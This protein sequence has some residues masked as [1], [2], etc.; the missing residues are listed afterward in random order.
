L[1]KPL[2]KFLILLHLEEKEDVSSFNAVKIEGYSPKV[3]S[4]HI[5]LL[6]DANFIET[7]PVDSKDSLGI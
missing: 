2:I 6:S 1:V 5:K 4:Y 7:K 3:V